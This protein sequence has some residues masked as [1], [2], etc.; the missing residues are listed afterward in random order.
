MNDRYEVRFGYSGWDVFRLNDYGI[1]QIHSGL[2][3]FEEAV[4]A[5]QVAA[6]RPL[7]V[8]LA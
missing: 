5:A 4:R 1:T 7:R 8:I 2:P 3:S 6:G